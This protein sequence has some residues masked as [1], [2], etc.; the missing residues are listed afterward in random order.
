MIALKPAPWAVLALV[1]GVG[2][3]ALER[4]WGAAAPQGSAADSVFAAQVLSGISGSSA[5]ACE[6]ALNALA[7]NWGGYSAFRPPDTDPAYAALI[8][9]VN[10]RSDDARSVPLLRRALEREDRCVRRVAARLLGHNRH[11]DAAAALLDAI[12]HPN[13]DVRAV[14]AVGLGYREYREALDPLVTALADSAAGV[15]AG[16]AWALGQIADLRATDPLVHVLERDRDAGVRRAAA[17]ALG[18]LN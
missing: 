11:P 17:L 16:A 9:W 10:Q 3:L 1:V 8:E 15:R 7:G 12:H 6:L 18:T 4:P 2:A 5:V 14:A 13:P